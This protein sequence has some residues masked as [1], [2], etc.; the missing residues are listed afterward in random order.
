MWQYHYPTTLEKTENVKRSKDDNLRWEIKR[1]WKL[2]EVTIYPVFI[3]AEGMVSTDLRDIFNALLT[4]FYKKNIRTKNYEKHILKH[5]VIDKCR[6]C[7]N[8]GESIEHIMAG[9]PALSISAYLARHNQVAK[10]VHQHLGLRHELIEKNT[11]Y[12]K[13]SP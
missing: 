5:D 3:S 7:G 13:Y 9:C 12:Y 10:L 1:L 4:Q 8:I 2:N 11:P 6:R